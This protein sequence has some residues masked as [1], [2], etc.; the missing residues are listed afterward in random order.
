MTANHYKRTT[1]PVCMTQSSKEANSSA[2]ALEASSFRKSVK[3][4][5]HSQNRCI[6]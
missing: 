5:L 6:D 2:F 1:E 4:Q 3:V